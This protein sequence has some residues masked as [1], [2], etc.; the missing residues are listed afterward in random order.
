MIRY[1]FNQRLK[2]WISKNS[3]SIIK[4]ITIVFLIAYFLVDSDIVL[5]DPVMGGSVGKT[6]QNLDHQQL[7]KYL[8][9]FVKP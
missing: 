6:F 3:V 5:A 1:G 8:G 7:M 4:F 9:K 2:L